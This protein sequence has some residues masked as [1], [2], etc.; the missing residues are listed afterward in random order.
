[1]KKLIF[2]GLL[3]SLFFIVIGCGMADMTNPTANEFDVVD[4]G[5]FHL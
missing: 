4:R 2:A 3:V 5:G 1:M